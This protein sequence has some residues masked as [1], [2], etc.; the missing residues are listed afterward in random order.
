VL[1]VVW[2]GN[3]VLEERSIAWRTQLKSPTR[4]GGMG[5]AR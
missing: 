2:R 1:E 5:K 4:R 3:G